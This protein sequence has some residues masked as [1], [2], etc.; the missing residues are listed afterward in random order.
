MVTWDDLR[1]AEREFNQAAAAFRR[2]SEDPSEWVGAHEELRDSRRVLVFTGESHFE[3]RD[4]LL[5][6]VKRKRARLAAL[7]ESWVR[8][9]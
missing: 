2:Y 5:E 6:Q 1:E 9:E 8:A 7:R 4:Y 3:Q